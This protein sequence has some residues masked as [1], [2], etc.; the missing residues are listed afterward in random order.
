ML[1]KTASLNME[2][3]ESY[4]SEIDYPD[5]SGDIEYEDIS[6]NIDEIMFVEYK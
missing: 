1:I 2:I 4:F 6:Y 5:S 3:S